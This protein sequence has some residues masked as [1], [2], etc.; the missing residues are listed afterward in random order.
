VQPEQV[1]R[2]ELAP[3]VDLYVRAD[4]ARRHARLIERLLQTARDDLGRG[5]A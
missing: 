3:G 5:S 4:A 1:Q 2:W